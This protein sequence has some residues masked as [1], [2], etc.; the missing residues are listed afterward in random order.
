MAAADCL[1]M[2]SATGVNGV[3]IARGSLGNP[4]IFRDCLAL[5]AGNAAPSRPTIAEQG[6]V[7]AAHF[8][9]AIGHY[10]AERAGRVLVRAGVRY[11]RLHPQRKLLGIAFQKVRSTPDY[12]AVL[13]EWYGVEVA[14]VPEPVASAAR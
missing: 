13:R 14:D 4:W 10:G 3:T 8:A 2:L 6:E 11:S 1:G 5:A 12:A 7:L 9:E